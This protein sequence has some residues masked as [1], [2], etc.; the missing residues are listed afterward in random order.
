MCLFAITTAPDFKIKLH[1]NI[2]RTPSN[3]LESVLVKHLISPDSTKSV[4][5]G[6]DLVSQLLSNCCQNDGEGSKTRIVMRFNPSM[7]SSSG[8][9]IPG[10]ANRANG[11]KSEKKGYFAQSQISI[12]NKIPNVN[13][14]F[15]LYVRCLCCQNRR[16]HKDPSL[17]YTVLC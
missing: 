12:I 5:I 2:K 6:P 9:F 4:L 16:N 8:K 3:F 13:V 10:H 17:K 7:I 15:L 11:S 1:H 14:V